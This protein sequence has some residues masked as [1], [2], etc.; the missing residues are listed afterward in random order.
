MDIHQKEELRRLCLRWMAE[1]SALSF[2]ARS[3]HAGTA[4]DIAATLPEIEDALSF[5]QS[6]G[7]LD[8]VPN[9]MGGTKYF[10]INAGG[11]LSHESGF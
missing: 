7:L 5:L 9:K 3:V 1:R 2:N 10:K 6:S 11:I 4:R 8:D